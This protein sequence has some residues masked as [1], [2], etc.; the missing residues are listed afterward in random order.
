M[1]REDAQGKE[2]IL[3]DTGEGDKK[4]YLQNLK[5]VL[6]EEKASLGQILISHWHPDH[7]GGAR[8]VLREFGLSDKECKV[9]KY[10]EKTEADKERGIYGI[11][12]DFLQDGQHITTEDASLRTIYTPGHTVDH[13]VFQL[14]EENA[15]FSGDCI[16]GETPAVFEDYVEYM[17]SL[18]RILQLQPSR[19]YPGHGPVVEN[20]VKRIQTYIEHRQIR[21][22]Q[23]LEAIKSKHDHGITSM[24]IVEVVYPGLDE[25][26][27]TAAENN[28]LVQLGKLLAEGRVLCS[29]E[30][31]FL[32]NA[33]LD[34]SRL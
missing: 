14:E 18:E 11:D 32:V 12:L 7:I 1:E 26:L 2:R 23:Y 33:S 15:L 13:V 4:N 25:A 3:L 19:I 17:K 28:V 10:P 29:E 6:A 8:E 20:A 16:L 24:E 27:K 22:Q 31:W 9:S 5:N 34:S 21:E 30:R